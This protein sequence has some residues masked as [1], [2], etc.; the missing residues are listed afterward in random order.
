MNDAHIHLGMSLIFGAPSQTA[1]KALIDIH[2]YIHPPVLEAAS[3]EMKFLMGQQLSISC[4]RFAQISFTCLHVMYRKY[5][6]RIYSI[7]GYP[8]NGFYCN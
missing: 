4:R 1:K 6:I 3:H 7:T 2:M 5:Y 8:I